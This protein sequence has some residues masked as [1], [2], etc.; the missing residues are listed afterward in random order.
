MNKER[1]LELYRQW[2]HD[3]CFLSY[4]DKKHPSYIEL[5]HEGPVILPWVLGRLQDSIGHDS[6]E[7]MDRDNDPW[8]SIVLIGELA[9][10][11]FDDFPDEKRGH[12]P[13][14]R[15]HLLAWGQSKG[16][17]TESKSTLRR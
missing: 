11:S 7:A 12:L 3:T 15:S 16:L 10:D 6:G 2:G 4:H 5:L 17:I 8:L 1:F 13:T 9:E 14:L